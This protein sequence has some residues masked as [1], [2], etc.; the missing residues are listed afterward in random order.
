MPSVWAHVLK[1]G[2][3]VSSAMQVEKVQVRGALM[4]GPA[5][6]KRAWDADSALV[7]ERSAAYHVYGHP[8]IVK[9]LGEVQDGGTGALQGLLYELC[10]GDLRAVLTA[11]RGS[12][13]PAQVHSVLQQVLSAV[14][15]VHQIGYVHSD[16]KP[17]NLMVT[18]T[19]GASLFDVKVGDFGLAARMGGPRRGGSLKYMSPE[20]HDSWGQPTGGSTKGGWHADARDDVFSVAVVALEMLASRPMSQALGGTDGVVAAIRGG[21]LLRDMQE[22]AGVRCE[23]QLL[24]VLQWCLLPVAA[25]PLP[26]EVLAH[27]RAHTELTARGDARWRSDTP[28]PI[29]PERTSKIFMVRKRPPW[30]PS[31]AA[32]PGSCVFLLQEICF[33]SV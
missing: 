3:N 18:V 21:T 11:K 13:R 15:H 2:A 8:H 14:Q 32:I 6:Y 4:S 17:E 29:H 30:L 26:C 19:P 23:A 31:L 7:W 1:M 28:D 12:L 33:R 24:R 27:L 9:L 25:R 22:L 16:I 10:D 5:A 20:R